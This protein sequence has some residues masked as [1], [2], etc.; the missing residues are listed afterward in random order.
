MSHMGFSDAWGKCSSKVNAL[1]TRGKS[2]RRERDIGDYVVV[3]NA[4]A[5]EVVDVLAR[6]E[7]GTSKTAPDPLLDWCYHGVR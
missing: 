1:F 7:C 3:Q 4:S 5:Y 6:G 2:G